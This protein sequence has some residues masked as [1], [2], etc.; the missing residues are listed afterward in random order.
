M[1]DIVV[2][3]L[4]DHS[5]TDV[6]GINIPAG[7]RAIRKREVLSSMLSASVFLAKREYG[8]RTGPDGGP[9]RVRPIQP[10]QPQ[11]VIVC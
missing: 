4:F 1:L 11:P 5:G 10:S 7:S 2:L 8:P 6:V 9:G 3:E